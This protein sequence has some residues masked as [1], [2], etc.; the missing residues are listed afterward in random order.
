MQALF[1]P[2]IIKINL[3]ER[4]GNPLRQENVLIGIHT[5]ATHKNNINISP[6][7]SDTTG[8]F[9]ITK[10]QIKERADIFIDYGIMD[11][12]SLESARPDIQ[13]YYWGN[14]SLNRY[15]NYW[16]MLLKNKKTRVKTEM[17][18]KLLGHMEQRFAEI[19]KRE[20]EELE[21]YSNCFNR[22]TKL[23]DDIILVSD[24]WDRPENEKAYTATLP[25]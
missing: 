4:H 1:I 22:Q 16:T 24:H 5:F 2:D 17:E 21:V 3:R 19:T 6:F 14:N 12:G 7:L 23:S 20:T 15:I 8:Q 25:V 11:Y 13:I 10:D 9:I 18:I